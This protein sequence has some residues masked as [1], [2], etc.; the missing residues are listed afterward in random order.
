MSVCVCVCVEGGR[1]GGG[2]RVRILPHW[3]R[4]VWGRGVWGQRL[5]WLCGWWWAADGWVGQ[6]SGRVRAFGRG[7]ASGCA[8]VLLGQPRAIYGWPLSLSVH[9]RWPRRWRGAGR[10]RPSLSRRLAGRTSR[11]VCEEEAADRSGPADRRRLTG[12]G[13]PSTSSLGLWVSLWVETRLLC[14]RG[15]ALGG[16]SAVLRQTISA[17]VRSG[18]EGTYDKR[19]TDARDGR[20]DVRV[21]C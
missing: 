21:T 17:D 12:A 1:R 20:T 4:G 3:G 18:G 6:A 19:G 5:G 9:L 11:F 13:A 14:G 2:G 15:S 16:D 7:L 8:C 10:R